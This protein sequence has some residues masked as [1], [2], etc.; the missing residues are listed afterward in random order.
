[1]ENIIFWKKI[2]SYS[3]SVIEK[4]GT[5]TIKTPTEC[6]PNMKILEWSPL[7]GKLTITINNAPFILIRRNISSEKQTWYSH[8]HNKEITVF[9]KPQTIPISDK[10]NNSGSISSPLTGTIVSLPITEGTF[11]R[12][13]TLLVTIESMKMENEIRAPFN[14]FIETIHISLG[15]MIEGGTH[16]LTLQKKQ[17]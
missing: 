16:L 11:V 17:E 13:N 3:V 9:T 6:I 4:S 1:M 12:T 15:D 8:S 5:V 7:R 10:K 14:G 2:I